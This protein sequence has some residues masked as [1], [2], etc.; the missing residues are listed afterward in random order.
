MFNLDNP[1]FEIMGKMVDMIVLGALWF[2]MSIPIVTIGAS[3]TA[4]YYVA[5]NQ[6]N[7]KDGYVVRNF[8]KSFKENFVQATLLFVI[9]L[10]IGS[11]AVINLFIIND[12]M[13]PISTSMGDNILKGLQLFI[14]LELWLVF[15]YGFALLSKISFTF[16][17]LVITS[18]QMANRHLLT[19][20]LSVVVVIGLNFAIMYFPILFLFG[21]AIYFTLTAFILKQIIK[22]YRPEVFDF[23]ILDDVFKLQ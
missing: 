14:L 7:G 19:S 13:A 12:F 4:A 10:V 9:L 6:L 1:I 23:E 8:F 15:F 3:T 17:G 2:I 16:K 11:V 5:F 21:G 18:L 20:F 22:K